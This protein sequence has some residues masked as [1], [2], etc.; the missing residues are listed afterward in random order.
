MTTNPDTKQ[1]DALSDSDEVYIN[2]LEKHF[3][4]FGSGEH[5]AARLVALARRGSTI[6]TSPLVGET[7]SMGGGSAIELAGENLPL[8]HPTQPAVQLSENEWVR[9]VAMSIDG[10]AF[11][12]KYAATHYYPKNAS[13]LFEKR[14]AKAT[15]QA[16]LAYT[17]LQQAIK[18]RGGA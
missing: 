13:K 15:R 2:G 5:D 17:T 18:T 7:S 16:S 10:N 6:P 3:I 8:S 4:E 9:L 14:R 1:N 12:E 11:Q